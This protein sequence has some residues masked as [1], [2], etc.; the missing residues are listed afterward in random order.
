M[1]T[2]RV[3]DGMSE[4]FARAE[5]VVSRFF[6]ERVDD[7]T[8]GTIQ[9][10]GERYVLVRAA[11]LSV[12]FFDLVRSLY[13]EERREEAEEFARAILFDLA[14]AVGR[15]DAKNFHEQMKLTDPIAKLSAGPVHFAHAGWAF[16]D[17]FAESR[18]SADDDYC[19]IYDHPYS[20]ESDAWVRAG[21]SS[22]F[23]VCIMNSGY[24]S[25]WCE[26]SF[27]QKLVAA[28]LLCRGKGDETCRFVMAPPHRIAHRIKEYIASHPEI[29]SRAANF[30]IPD[31][32]ARK[33]EEEALRRQRDALERELRQTQKL[34]ALGRLAGG[35]AHDFNNIISV[36][37][38]QAM[39]A[40]RRLG[41]DDPVSADLSKIIRAGE[42][43]ASLTQQLLA[44]GRSQVARNELLDLNRVVEEM[45]RMIERVIG[46]DIDLRLELAADAGAVQAD[47]TQ[48]EQ[49]LM[50]LSVNARDAMPNGGVLT[51]ATAR[52]GASRVMLSVA[53]TGVGMDEETRARAFEPFF[54]TKGNRGTGLG[55]STVYGIVSGSSGTI[56]IDSRR[57]EGTVVRISLPRA[58][59]VPQEA[60]SLEETTVQG[61]GTVL[62]AE[63]GAELREVIGE[64]L[65]AF[66]Y[67]PILAANAEEALRILENPK[68]KVHTLLTDVVMPG[69]SGVEL[70]SRAL[71][72]RP[73]L[74]VVFMSGY[75]PDPRHR[76]LFARDGAAFLQKPF[77]PQ[78]LAIKLAAL[79][80]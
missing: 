61:S 18:A 74:N 38:G 12:E 72:L 2:V 68:R 1:R 25:G 58:E 35:I 4:L 24:S 75:A 16:V 10:H 8:R 54:T 3:P 30:Q 15:T 20:F 44:F 60:E 70:A 7:P 33:R 21:R 17:I 40:Q 32:F 42:R 5:E 34:E 13:G 67:K 50:N 57:G 27:Q 47:K 63:D 80:D 56:G 69:V 14:H 39:L 65:Q 19:L 9:I 37:L 6:S 66:G 78:E 71:E 26:E 45:G 29:A 11:A 23:P 41:E 49:I 52:D 73:S 76:A 48:L 22:K 64:S 43:A 79:R 36:V 46:E 28:E 59:G 55:L 62:V 31:F 77:T 53:D 51:I